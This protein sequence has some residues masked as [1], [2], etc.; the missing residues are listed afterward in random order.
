MFKEKIR[1]YLDDVR[2]PPEG[3]NLVSTVKDMMFLVATE[4]VTHI[5]LDHDLGDA[6]ILVAEQ[7]LDVLP[8]RIGRVGR[9]V[10]RVE[11]NMAG[12]A[13]GADR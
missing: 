2:T 13:G 1:L 6:R 10:E 7:A 12:A 8:L 3:W 4:D 9:R 11:G 5:S